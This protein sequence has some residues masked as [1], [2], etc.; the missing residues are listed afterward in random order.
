MDIGKYEIRKWHVEEN[1][2]LDIGYNFVIRRDGVLEYGRDLDKDGDYLE[3]IGAH[4]RGYNTH[5]LG[6]CLIGGVDK[7]GSPQDNFTT[8]QYQTL[9]KL[10]RELKAD[11][12][13]AIIQGHRD[14]KGV[15]TD[16][17]SFDVR[18]W[19]SNVNNK[20]HEQCKDTK[21]LS[22][23]FYSLFLGLWKRLTLRNS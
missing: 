10:L 13:D 2:W 6:I 7:D 1:G 5:S 17:P 16:C 8:L 18:S 19:W 3:E 4:V 15:K 21:H 11:Y 20:E 23:R 22:F 9:A 12:K 14:F